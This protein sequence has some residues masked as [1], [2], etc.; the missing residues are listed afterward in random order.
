MYDF[1]VAACV[2]QGA[3]QCYEVLQIIWIMYGK[4][5]LWEA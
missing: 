3:Y 1:T 4:S 2:Y 5:A